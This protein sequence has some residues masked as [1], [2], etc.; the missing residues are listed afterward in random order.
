LKIPYDK[1]DK[2]AQKEKE[3]GVMDK[4][5]RLAAV[6]VIPWLVALA[7][8]ACAMIAT[9][10]TKIALPGSRHSNCGKVLAK[11]DDIACEEGVWDIQAKPVPGFPSYRVNRF[12]ASFADELSDNEA[13]K[14][15]LSRLAGLGNE[16][17]RVE[18]ANLPN[19]S[20][21]DL[22]AG[23][24]RKDV[25]A[26]MEQ[27]AVHLAA[28]DLRDPERLRLL[29]ESAGVPDDYST[30]MRVIGLYPISSWF[31]MRGVRAFHDEA[32]HD[33]GRPGAM[34][35]GEI[36]WYI[37][38]RPRP[39]LSPENRAAIFKRA[40]NKSAL[41]IPEPDPD[42][43]L[44]LFD[45]YAPIWSISTVDD[46]DKVGRPFWKNEEMLQVDIADPVVYRHHSFTRI[47]DQILLQLNY[48]I[49]FPRR[50]SQGF[51]DYL[52]GH[53]DGLIWRTTLNGQGRVML[54]DSIH[55]CGCYHKY[56][57]VS[58][59]LIPLDDPPTPEP[60]LI[61]SQDIPSSED[62]RV[63][64]HLR[65]RAHYVVGLST[66]NEQIEDAVSYRFDEYDVL[67]NLP[68]KDRHRSMFE[69]DGLVPG[70]ERAEH[71]FVW[72]MGVNC[73]GAMRQWGTHAIA[74]V[75]RQH[76]DDARLFESVF[77]FKDEK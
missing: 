30:L 42:E 20:F 66:A 65:S 43:L 32:R 61:F 15:W 73:A 76:F 46:S 56:Y 5:I 77:E 25:S 53:F 29:K 54:Y 26:E 23:F 3:R 68:Y 47:G 57:A 75:G 7:F 72:P 14:E 33:F 17:R 64:I 34:G 31:V 36:K 22:P 13:D 12:L 62:G 58:S 9:R 52:S 69:P 18:L 74:L 8:S 6:I 2:V 38:D 4:S 70:T 60:P 27:C 11:L 67:R 50:P 1:C 37:P 35:N 55:P 16:A 39:A 63:V 10:D 71:W 51:F 45:Y 21:Q 59:N 49:W 19:P 44:L 41:D 28:E 48:V 40:R 24:S